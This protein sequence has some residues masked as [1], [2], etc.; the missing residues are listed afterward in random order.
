M[1]RRRTGLLVLAIVAGT[2]IFFLGVL[3]VLFLVVLG[4]ALIA[5]AQVFGH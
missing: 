2:V 3:A 5:L 1:Q 4:P